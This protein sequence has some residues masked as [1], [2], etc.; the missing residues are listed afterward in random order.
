MI[1]WIKDSLARDASL[2][3]KQKSAYGVTLSWYVGYCH[4]REWSP[5]EDRKIGR[6]FFREVVDAK[7][8]EDWLCRWVV[9]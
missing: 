8:P 4:K 5:V 1:D 3:Q 2:T 7:T 6:E 9:L